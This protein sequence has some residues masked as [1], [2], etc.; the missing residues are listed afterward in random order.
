MSLSTLVLILR[1]L[2]PFVKEIV[3]RD[4]GLREFL[5]TNLT[6]SML[7]GCLVFVF[8]ALYYISLIADTAVQRAD[9]LDRQNQL[10][11]QQLGDRVCLPQTLEPVLPQRPTDRQTPPV[12]R[13]P[14]KSYTEERLKSHT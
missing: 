14:I 5:L 2:W 6:A 11:Q 7:A 13:M 10:L 1:S 12:P 8:L 9:E 3:L 4:K